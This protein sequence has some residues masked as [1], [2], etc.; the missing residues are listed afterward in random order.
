M[1]IGILSG[2]ETVGDKVSYSPVSPVKKFDPE[3]AQHVHGFFISNGP[4][5]KQRVI[6]GKIAPFDDNKCINAILAEAIKSNRTL[7]KT[8]TPYDVCYNCQG[9]NTICGKYEG[10]NSPK[11]EAELKMTG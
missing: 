1:G 4:E 11:E 8:K 10:F 9:H 2:T 7:G 3:K 5:V 6:R